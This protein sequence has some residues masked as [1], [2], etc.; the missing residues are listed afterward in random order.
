MKEK[1]LLSLESLRATSLPKKSRDTRQVIKGTQKWNRDRAWLA[2]TPATAASVPT[3]A[4][5]WKQGGCPLHPTCP[6]ASGSQLEGVG[7]CTFQPL[8]SSQ[9]QEKMP[10]SSAWPILAYFSSHGHP[11]EGLPTQERPLKRT[12][13]CSCRRHRK[14]KKRTENVRTC[15]K[16]ET[17]SMFPAPKR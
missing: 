12:R 17:P 1:Q 3:R 9:A 6:A 8:C 14:Q 11:A 5:E 13:L 15:N 2:H 7:L 4:G 10:G 16:M